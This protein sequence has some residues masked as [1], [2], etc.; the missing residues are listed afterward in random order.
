MK[1]H[2]L[3]IIHLSDLHFSDGLCRP[4]VEKLIKDIGEQIEED[5]DIILVITGDFVTKNDFA[6]NKKNVENFFAGIRG[7]IPKDTNILD[8]ELVPGNHDGYRAVD[9]VDYNEGTYLSRLDAY[10]ELHRA[11]YKI[12]DI[13]PHKY[14]GTTVVDFYDRKVV[15]CRLDTASFE[16]TSNLRTQVF[17]RETNEDDAR[18]IIECIEKHFCQYFEEQLK[19]CASEY[20][21]IISENNH[22]EPDLSMV[23]SHHPLSLLNLINYD[24]VDE[25]LF[26][27]AFEVG[28]IMISGHVHSAGRGFVSYNTHQKIMLTTGLGW[29]D[30]PNELLRYSLYRINLDRKTCQ[31]T[32]RSS[33]RNEDFR[34]DA[35]SGQNYEFVRYDHMTLPLKLDSVGAAIH[36]KTI[37]AGHKRSIY[38]DMIVIEKIP[39]VLTAFCET[40]KKLEFKVLNYERLAKEKATVARFRSAWIAARNWNKEKATLLELDIKS[41]VKKE[42]YLVEIIKE[43][44][45]EVGVLL[46]KITTA[47]DLEN[48]KGVISSLEKIEWRVHA[49]QYK[50]MNLRKL[51]KNKDIYVSSLALD[52]FG[53]KHK[54]R[55][56]DISWDSLIKAAFEAG[57]KVLINSANPKIS[58][59]Q[60]EWSDFL[61]CVP[62]T[63][64]TSKFT[65]VFSARESRPL[66]T[67]GIS[68][69]VNNPQRLC[70]ATRLL[71][72]LDYLG[73]GELI[74]TILELFVSHYG[75]DT[76]DIIKD[77]R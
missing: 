25:A 1:T 8:V 76:N 32:V 19:R 26:R 40:R 18:K 35:T 51:K 38:A 30:D 16:M 50:G 63:S 68:F 21:N 47:S 62:I 17:K 28:D 73:I 77:L 9:S 39:N 24:T 53:E 56:S 33:I 36:A 11:I 14:S 71:Y 54:N 45:C 6:K 29:Q 70:E 34:Q 44:C 69:K 42:K 5:Q 37:S 66:L 57:H 59:Q 4:V 22:A 41:A 67:F 61:T 23:L 55:P 58:K 43:I 46:H 65:K 48:S 10:E 31:I 52:V 49:R 20:K 2:D 15:F 27:N 74:E 12:F 13:Q 72:I 3:C 7:V 64:K 60:T 75:F